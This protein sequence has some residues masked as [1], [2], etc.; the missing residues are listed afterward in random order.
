MNVGNAS[1]TL[2]TIVES[3]SH[4]VNGAVS[5]LPNASSNGTLWR[6]FSLTNMADLM[7][8]FLVCPLTFV[9]MGQCVHWSKMF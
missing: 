2:I 3:N 9:S 1:A 8:C 7:I 4:S 6:I 5:N